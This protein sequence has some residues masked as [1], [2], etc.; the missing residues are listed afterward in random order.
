MLFDLCAR[1]FPFARF[2]IPTASGRLLDSIQ[3][4]FLRVSLSRRLVRKR[5][6]GSGFVKVGGLWEL[7]PVTKWTISLLHNSIVW[8][9]RLV[10]L[11]CH[12]FCVLVIQASFPLHWVVSHCEVITRQGLWIFYLI[13]A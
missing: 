7:S 12:S 9:I 2:Q 5:H 6:F 10:L 3:I 13:E 8:F 11:D 1:Q 4:M